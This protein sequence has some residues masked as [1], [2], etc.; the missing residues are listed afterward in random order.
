VSTL[1][2]SWGSHLI[3]FVASGCTLVLELVAGQVLAPFVRV[4]ML[5]VVA[6]GALAGVRARGTSPAAAIR[7]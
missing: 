3:V 4:S 5:T 2:R 7:V 6:L 1:D